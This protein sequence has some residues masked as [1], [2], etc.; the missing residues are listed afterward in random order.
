MNKKM[1]N[2]GRR[3]ARRWGRVGQ[4]LLGL[5]IRKRGERLLTANLKECG[6]I[7]GGSG[8]IRKIA[9]HEC[10]FLSFCWGRGLCFL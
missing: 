9:Q 8:G 5:F 1:M 6:S 2:F 7:Y 3:E 4:Q 10:L